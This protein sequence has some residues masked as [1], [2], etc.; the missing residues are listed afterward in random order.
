MNGCLTEGEKI[1]K[2]SAKAEISGK[3][4]CIAES[5][6]GIKFIMGTSPRNNCFIYIKNY[7]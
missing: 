1:S 6:C 7:M 3:N 4:E 2:E 5:V